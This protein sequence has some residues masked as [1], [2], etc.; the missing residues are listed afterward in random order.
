MLCNAKIAVCQ[1]CQQFNINISGTD[2]ISEGSELSHF[3][4]VIHHVHLNH[5]HT[6]IDIDSY[7]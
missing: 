7:I 2:V 3:Q 4:F 6:I 1:V 5:H